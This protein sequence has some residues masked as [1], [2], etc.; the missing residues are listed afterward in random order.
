MNGF[1]ILT[2]SA[3]IL[4]LNDFCQPNVFPC[5][6]LMSNSGIAVD[7][8]IRCSDRY[9]DHVAQI[10]TF[11]SFRYRAVVAGMSGCVLNALRVD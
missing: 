10:I 3:L 11:E 7:E 6:I 2:L 5:P 8:V 1:L 4:S 9:G